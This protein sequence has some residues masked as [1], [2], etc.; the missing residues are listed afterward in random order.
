MSITSALNQRFIP[1]DT[2]PAPRIE[3]VWL[4]E[5]GE[6][7]RLTCMQNLV[8]DLTVG[9]IRREQL[10]DGSDDFEDVPTLTIGLDAS[11]REM[12][13]SE[14]TALTEVDAEH[15][16][17]MMPYRLTAHALWDASQLGGIPVYVVSGKRAL[18]I[19]DA[20]T[21]SAPSQETVFVLQSDNDS[22]ITAQLFTS[23]AHAEQALRVILGQYTIHTAEGPASKFGLEEIEQKIQES[24]QSAVNVGDS[25]GYWIQEQ[26]I[27][28]KS[29]RRVEQS[30]SEKEKRLPL[31]MAIQVFGHRKVS[32]AEAEL[33]PVQ[34]IRLNAQEK[35]WVR[36]W[37]WLARQERA[38]HQLEVSELV[39]INLDCLNADAPLE[40]GRALAKAGSAGFK[41][42]SVKL[43]VIPDPVASSTERIRSL[44]AQDVFGDYDV[45]SSIPEWQWIE[46][47]A[48]FV[49]TRNSQ[50]GVWEFV[51]NMSIAL[52][53]A[54]DRLLRIIEETREAGISWL[55][56]HQGT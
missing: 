15:G 3:L 29:T 4:E 38:T 18:R 1:S 54:P 2:L 48:S 42:V 26:T 20:G 5:S 14:R 16:S 27:Q 30:K 22:G 17:I 28:G 43:C 19:D 13:E 31:V 51:L 47:N 35:G 32:E 8:L 46:E 45:P 21:G 9:D 34:E 25:D 12:A 56:V 36:Q 39:S 44:M 37:A 6:N 11:A 50:D 49:H 40:L 23:R 41:T 53:G 55:L 33:V 7:D 52:E 10:V 24:R